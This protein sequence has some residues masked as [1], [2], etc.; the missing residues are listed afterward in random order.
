MKSIIMSA[1]SIKAIQAGRKTQTRRVIKTDNP[2]EWEGHNN[3]RN[4]DGGAEVPC[5]IVRKDG[6]VYRPNEKCIIYPK[7]DVGDICY[8]KEVWAKVSDWT[9][10]DESV[11][12]P[13]GIIYKA[14][15]GGEEHPKWHSPLHMPQAAARYF[16]EITAVEVQRLQSMKWED[17]E[18]EG[19]KYVKVEGPTNYDTQDDYYYDCDNA[20]I[21]EF[22]KV[23]NAL[24]KKRGYSFESNPWVWVIC[25]EMISREEAE[26]SGNK[27]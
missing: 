26:R 21:D 6:V 7:Y 1:D 25:F 16:I 20:T 4:E 2:I 17:I 11:G 18:A 19:I 22:I 12:Q 24:N 13:D 3:C 5:Y 8:V 27:C 15:W 9:T 10:V 14:D 23:W